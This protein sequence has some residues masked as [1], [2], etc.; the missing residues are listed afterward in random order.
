MGSLHAEARLGGCGQVGR[1]QVGGAEGDRLEVPRVPTLVSGPLC[2]HPVLL[3]QASI[4]TERSELN[5]HRTSPLHSYSCWCLEA[6]GLKSS[7]F[8]SPWH[9]GVSPTLPSTSS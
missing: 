3:A 1:G 9:S 2:H 4:L 6:V 5:T 8:T 7:G